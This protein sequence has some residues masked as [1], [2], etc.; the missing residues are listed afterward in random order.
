[1][2]IY[3]CCWGMRIVPTF[4]SALSISSAESMGANLTR[5]KPPALGASCAVAAEVSSGKS[6]I[7]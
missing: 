2:T 4:A 5:A 6:T 1:M 3:Y 7:E